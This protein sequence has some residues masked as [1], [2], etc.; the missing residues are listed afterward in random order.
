MVNLGEA[1][2]NDL[3]IGSLVEDIVGDVVHLV[4][5]ANQFVLVNF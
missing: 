1:R 4:D 5:V 3:P 2:I